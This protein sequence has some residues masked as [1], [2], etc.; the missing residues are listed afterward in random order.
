MSR[1]VRR[2]KQAVGLGDTNQSV[3]QVPAGVVDAYDLAIFA[4][5][6]VEFPI[7]SFNLAPQRRGVDQV[8]AGQRI[9]TGR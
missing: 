5:A 6:I 7:A 3:G 2:I 4:V 1:P 8:I 9:H